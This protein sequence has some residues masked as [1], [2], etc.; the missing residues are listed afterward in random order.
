MR[1]IL[2]AIHHHYPTKDR[3]RH[4]LTPVAHQVFPFVQF[5]DCLLQQIVL[6]KRRCEHFKFIK[7]QGLVPRHEDGN[8]C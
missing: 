7:L 6:Q 2:S 4:R 5:L 8:V 1:N 3:R